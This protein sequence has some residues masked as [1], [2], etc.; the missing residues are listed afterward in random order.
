MTVNYLNYTLMNLDTSLAGYQANSEWT[1]I[2]YKP[3]RNEIFYDNWIEPFPF[4]EIH[5]KILI[6]RKP[7]FVLQNYCVPALMLCIIT[8]ISFYIP[9]P[10]GTKHIMNTTSFIYFFP[11]LNVL[12]IFK[13][14]KWESVLCW[15]LPF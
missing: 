1:L 2:D 14:R 13:S 4:S 10:Q 15:L 12:I 6:R 9:F 8:L 3:F 5:Y 11:K 7:L